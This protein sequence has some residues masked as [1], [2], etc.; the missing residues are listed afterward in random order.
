MSKDSKNYPNEIKMLIVE[1]ASGSYCF[2]LSDV[3]EIIRMPEITKLPNAPDFIKGLIRLRDDIIPLVDIRNK[4]GLKSIEDEDNEF[5]E[6]LHA[7]E[8]DH[9]NWVNELKNC[10]YEKRKFTL[11][12][13][14]H[15]CKFGKWYDKFE[16]SNILVSNFLE[17]FESPH[18]KI[19]SI[20]RI[21]I[22]L[23]ND[24]KYDKAKSMVEVDAKKELEELVSL[25]SELKQV[26]SKSHR[27]FAVIFEI[28]GQYRA[29]IAD[30]IDQIVSI[31]VDDIE[32]SDKISE[33][34]YT[35]GICKL[36]EHLYVV[37]DERALTGSIE[38][39]ANLAV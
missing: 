6:M 13:D 33:S 39:Y 16:T 15:Q 25:F 21:I 30:K 11:T 9:I 27:E 1:V 22:D 5:F 3:K 26:I 18:K 19:H 34:F 12:T 20:G 35:K 24:D 7:R 17:K 10:V 36:N 28:D 4:L 31:S 14:P 38:D 8:Q 37:L 2:E 29:F 32:Q 23:M